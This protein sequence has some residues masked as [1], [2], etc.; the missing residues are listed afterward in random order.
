MP[1][2]ALRSSGTAAARSMALG[3]VVAHAVRRKLSESKFFE[4]RCMIEVVLR[5]GDDAIVAEGERLEIGTVVA[6]QAVGLE[7]LWGA[8][9]LRGARRRG[10]RRSTQIVLHAPHHIRISRLLR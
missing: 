3:I 7:S 4:R 10:R 1:Q 2:I 5:G 8:A 9:A 6:R